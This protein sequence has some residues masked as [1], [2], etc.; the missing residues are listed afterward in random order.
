[1]NQDY[2]IVKMQGKML[3]ILRLK[4]EWFLLSQMSSLFL[5]FIIEYIIF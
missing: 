1:M 4:M 2:M 3:D 5:K